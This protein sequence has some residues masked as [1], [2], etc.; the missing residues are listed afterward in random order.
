MLTDGEL[1]GGLLLLTNALCSCLFLPVLPL[2]QTARGLD[3][4]RRRPY[5]AAVGQ[6]SSR[7]WDSDSVMAALEGETHVVM[8]CRAAL[9]C[10]GAD[11]RVYFDLLCC[12]E[13]MPRR[14]T[15][16]LQI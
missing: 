4:L 8:K 6:T 5:Y 9:H 2:T 7:C 10:D 15:R 3:E 16:S 13:Q 12:E 11:G 1:G 14:P